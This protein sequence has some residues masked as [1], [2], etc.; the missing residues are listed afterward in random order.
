MKK[1]ITYVEPME[2]PDM[3]RIDWSKVA[4][5]VRGYRGQW[6][7]VPKPLNPSVS[8]HIKRGKYP[9]ISPEEFEVTTRRV[10]DDPNRSWIFLRTRAG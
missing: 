10:G 9:Y 6:C 8:M 4:E 5:E 7:R 1:K 2:L 3:G